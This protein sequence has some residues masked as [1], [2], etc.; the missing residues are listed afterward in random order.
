MVVGPGPR[1]CFHLRAGERPARNRV[2]LDVNTSDRA[3]EVARLLALGATR[4]REGDGYT[5][6]H[7]PEGNNFCVVSEV[8]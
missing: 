8:S 2:H 6:L 7:N 4:V 3:G 1:L 5:V